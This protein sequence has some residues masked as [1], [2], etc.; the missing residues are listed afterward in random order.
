MT[1]L[2]LRKAK[3]YPRAYGGTRETDDRSIPARTGE[4]RV[5]MSPSSAEQGGVYPR[6]YGGTVYGYAE[7]WGL[8]PR[9]R[10]NHR[11]AANIGAEPV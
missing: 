9:V 4:P 10:G 5:Q 11:H 3:V 7:H 2:R 8:S 1:R 6:A